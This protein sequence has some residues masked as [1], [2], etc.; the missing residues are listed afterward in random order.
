MTG[1]PVAG[2]AAYVPPQRIGFKA[3][4]AADL[5]LYR[6][7][8]S[9]ALDHF[10]VSDYSIAG[11][12]RHSNITAQITRPSRP[13]L[14][15][16]VRTG[17]SVSAHTE[18]T[19]LLAVRG[20]TRVLTV[21]PYSDILNDMTVEVPHPVDGSLLE[22]SLF[23][24][25]EGEPL[26][27]HLTPASYHRL[28]AMAAELH[29][30]A[31]SWAA[32]TGLAPLRWDQTMY[33]EGTRLVV[34][35]P[36]HSAYVSSREARK[37]EQVVTAADAELS[38]LAALSNP[39]FLHGNIEM[40]NVLVDRAGRLRLMDF[41]DVLLGQPVHDIAVTLYYGSERE[42]YPQ[43]VAAFRAGYGTIREWPELDERVLQLLMAARA[44][45]LLNHALLTEP[46][47]R[48]VVAR[49]LPLILRVA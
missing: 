29:N 5:W 21:E 4:P 49:L 9:Q 8:V 16:R 46:D 40:W 11:F 42:D 28:G 23:Q 6:Q 43:L 17:P 34:A 22:C 44:T 33:Y 14:A 30:F 2:A 41:E 18:L 3:L 45:M 37:V 31:A 24:W 13:G 20:A 36:E 15:L 27:A 48:P 25:A 12:V 26:A 10:R 35:R 47:P 32:P 38:R 7:V 1:E 19:W 39:I